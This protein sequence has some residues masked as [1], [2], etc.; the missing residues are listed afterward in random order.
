MSIITFINHEENEAGQTLSASAIAGIYGI[1]HAYKTLLVSVN[2][3]DT[4][5]E[6][7]FFKKSRLNIGNLMGGLMRPSNDTSNG[8]EGLL[9]MFSSNRVD[10]NVI[11]T[12]AR[13]ILRDRLDVLLPTKS[14]DL[15]DFR[16]SGKFYPSLL[17][18][19]NHVY[20]VVIADI[21]LDLGEDTVQSI[22]DKSSI[23]IV[24]LNQNPE[25]IEKFAQLK[26]ADERYRK[27]NVLL[28]MG[29]CNPESRYSPK[30]A[31][32][33]L[34]E[35]DAPIIIPYNVNFADECC[36][37]NMVD[38]LL[39]AKS[40]HYTD[41]PDGYFYAV[42]KDGVERIDNIRKQVDFGLRKDVT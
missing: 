39:K 2:R 27:S 36:D 29:K 17:D 15:A 18:V 28:G 14:K 5:M 9:R 25:S 30:N 42:V 35:K 21:D 10:E 8:V 13:P 31:S 40:L 4:K 26:N 1:E 32:R 41:R 34:K 20:D 33:T 7:A 12:Y 37:G 38:F 16:N 11:S 22:L 24:C 19:A 6:S 3:G 23:I